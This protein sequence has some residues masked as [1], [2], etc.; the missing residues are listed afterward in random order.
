MR[1]PVGLLDLPQLR[2]GSSSYILQSEPLDRWLEQIYGRPGL[3]LKIFPGLF[4]PNDPWEFVPLH[5]TVVVQNTFAGHG[6]APQVVDF[7]P[8]NGECMAQVVEYC[9]ELDSAPPSDADLAPFWGLIDLYK[10]GT[11]S[12]IGKCGV[13][14]LKWD[15]LRVNAGRNWSNGRLLDWGGKYRRDRYPEWDE[16]Q[17]ARTVEE[18]DDPSTAHQATTQGRPYA[19]DGAR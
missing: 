12:R 11:R 18:Q 5:E 7:G 4:G 6:W 13:T 3:C 19:Q 8:L 9:R 15:F 14:R 17:P 10:I 1:V 2:G 16:P